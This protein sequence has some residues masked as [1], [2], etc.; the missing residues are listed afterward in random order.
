[1]RRDPRGLSEN[2]TGRC[3]NNAALAQTLRRYMG[4]R[5]PVLIVGPCGTG[6]SP[7]SQALGHCAVRQ[8][9]DVVFI[10]CAHLTQT[11]QKKR[12]RRPLA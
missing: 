11:Y 1:M 7:L 12:A 2:L 8:G 9:V 4:E 5:A 10:T 3:W 6:K